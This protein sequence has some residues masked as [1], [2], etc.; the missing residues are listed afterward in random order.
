M[1]CS[2]PALFMP[3]H[4]SAS[5]CSSG[6]QLLWWGWGSCCM[7]SPLAGPWYHLPF[8]CPSRPGDRLTTA[9]PQHLFLPPLPPLPGFCTHSLP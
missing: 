8:L 5:G 4:R 3:R 7:V 2:S 6:S 1:G 9:G